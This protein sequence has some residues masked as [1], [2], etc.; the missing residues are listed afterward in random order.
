[1]AEALDRILDP[2]FRV[3]FD[4]GLSGGK[5]TIE[6]PAAAEDDPDHERVRVLEIY[7]SHQGLARFPQ[8]A[9]RIGR[10]NTPGRAPMLYDILKQIE[11][12]TRLRVTWTPG[13]DKEGK[14][15]AEFKDA[16]KEQQSCAEVLTTLLASQS[17]Q[18]QVVRQ[19]VAGEW[20]EFAKDCFNK[21]RKLDPKSN[22]GERAL[23]MV[24]I[25]FYSLKDYERMRAILREYLKV[26]DQPAYEYWHQANFW[27]GWILENEKKFNEAVTYYARAA[28]E[29]VV[30]YRPKP[31]P[32]AKPA[33]SATPAAA[34]PASATPETKVPD[35]QPPEKPKLDREAVR[36]L[37][38]YDTQF[39]LGEKVT[40]ALKDAGPDQFTDFMRIQ[41]HVN[42]V[43]DPTAQTG[44]TPINR[45]A[46]AQ[47]GFDLLCDVLEEQGLAVRIENLEPPIAERAYFRLASAYRKDGLMPQALENA[48]LLL[49]RYP[50]T[51]RRRETQGLMLA[52]YRGLKRFPEVIAMLETLAKEAK[53]PAEKRRIE[54][55]VAWIRFDMADYAGAADRLKPLLTSAQPG[56]E[57][58]RLRD[59]YARALM[60]AGQASAAAEQYALLTKEAALPSERRIAALAEWACKLSAGKASERDFP[61]E[62]TAF[63]RSYLDLPD[64]L[65]KARPRTDHA[66][67]TWNY[68]ALAQADVREGRWAKANERLQACASAP[69]DYLAA[70]ALIQLARIGMRTQDWDKARENLE[71]LLVFTTTA[72]SA[73]RGTY[74]LGE[75]LDQLGRKDLARERLQQ[76][77]D[78][79]PLS[80]YAERARARLGLPPGIG[81]KPVG[82]PGPS[83]ESGGDAAPVAVPTPAPVVTPTSVP[84]AQPNAK[85]NTKKEN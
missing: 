23:F 20:Y 33:A 14:L 63:L 65:R 57:L 83:G 52:V 66:R 44:F 25:N 69:D 55:E 85:P 26:F 72:E 74:H 64:D 60:R 56:E 32:D 76:V 28:E 84:N 35:A 22:Y 2:A 19:D 67:A 73:V 80:P 46:I 58:Q 68:W 53:D 50:E 48:Q 21:V 49:R 61:A 10:I 4:V 81:A 40:G 79:F 16:G 6:P 41:A 11:A 9:A 24:A 71:Y 36:A 7:D 70:D 30:V 54:I 29:R 59:A 3:A 78:R 62:E 51:E 77:V 34:A 27:I 82:N 1:M 75:C 38:A 8:L 42:L 18:A 15:A 17:L 5:P 39:V 31:G 45:P 13:I 43:L 37:M 12:A 47:S